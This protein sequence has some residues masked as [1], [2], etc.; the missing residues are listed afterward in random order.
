[1]TRVQRATTSSPTAYKAPRWLPGG[2]LQ[3]VYP[4]LFRR[5]RSPALQRE[6]WDTPD[7]D[8]I[9]VDWLEGRS[10]QPLVVLFHGLEGDSGSHY[11][12]AL[13][14]ALRGRGWRAA[15]PHFRGCSG[16][17]NLLPRAYHSG[18]YAEVDWVLRRMAV[19][20]PGARFAV[21][22]SLGGNALLKWLAH[23]GEAAQPVIAR[24]AAVSAPMDLTTA[25]HL[26]GR[27]LNRLYTWHFLRSLKPKS[28]AKLRRFPGLYN[29]RAVARARNLYEFDNLVTAPLH[30]FRSADDYWSRASSAPDLPHIRVPTLIVHARND[31]FLPGTHLPAAHAVSACVELEFPGAGG[32]A[33]FISGP[34]PGNLEWLPR[35]ILAFFAAGLQ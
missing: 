13:L 3:T 15:V 21:G 28:L 20:S 27:G 17:P 18:D 25:G 14:Q 5:M 1:L 23:A 16:A 30:G 11:A 19:R 31:P 6:R 34:F 2:H 4:Y 29:A 24:A 7:G 22:V 32:H 26:L 10:D 35:R 33:G 9:D 8:F 12:R